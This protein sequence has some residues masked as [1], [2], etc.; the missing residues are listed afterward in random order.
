MGKTEFMSRLAGALDFMSR[1]ERDDILY[2]YEEHFRIGFENGKT[3]EEIVASLGDPRFIAKQYKANY[4]VKQAETDSSIGNIVRAVL[5]AFGMGFF[6]LI[7][8][9]GPFFAIVGVL[10]GLFA[11][12]TGITLAGVGVFLALIIHPIAPYIPIN[13]AGVNEGVIVFTAVGLVC[14]GLL[15]IIGVSYLFKYFF[16]GT[17]RYLRWN[18]DIIKN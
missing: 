8:V 4:M 13:Y 12:G 5:A 14:M 15:F 2:D 1:E 10:I 11:A 3:E 9:V 17:V 7:F 18:M 16:K 6:N